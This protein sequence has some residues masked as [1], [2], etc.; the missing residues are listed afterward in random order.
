M[1]EE[2]SISKVYSS[3]RT[4]EVK[5]ILKVSWNYAIFFNSFISLMK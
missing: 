4:T 2:Y 5:L 1:P 3:D